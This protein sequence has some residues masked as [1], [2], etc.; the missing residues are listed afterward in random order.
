MKRTE[1]VAS[2]TEQVSANV[3]KIAIPD[4]KLEAFYVASYLPVIADSL[5]SIADSLEILS[6]RET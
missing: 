6:K 4:S 3:E 1:L 5:A 2:L